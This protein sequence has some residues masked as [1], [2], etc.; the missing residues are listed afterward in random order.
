[1]GVNAAGLR[2]KL[3]SFKKVLN[4]LKPSVFFIEESK[5][6]SPGRINIENYVIFEKIRSKPQN[7]G[8]L[9]IVSQS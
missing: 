3:L 1:M 8:G 2:S 4:D 7:G 5:M 6:K 9:A